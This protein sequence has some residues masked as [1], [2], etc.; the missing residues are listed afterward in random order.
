MS[1]KDMRWDSSFKLDIPKFHG[2]IRVDSF[3][4]WLVDVEEIL[5]LIRVPDDLL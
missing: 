2:E 4:D 3:L 1:L 5:E